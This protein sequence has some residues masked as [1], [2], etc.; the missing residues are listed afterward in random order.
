MG[1]TL[2]KHDRAAKKDSKN[3]YSVQERKFPL[4]SELLF[5]V[6]STAAAA[7]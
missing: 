3:I 6:L 4:K 2:C 1:N 5:E 7:V